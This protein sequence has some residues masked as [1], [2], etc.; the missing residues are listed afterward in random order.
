MF[1]VLIDI[2]SGMRLLYEMSSV[3]CEK[4][5]YFKN[6]CFDFVSLWLKIEEKYILLK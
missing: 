6:Y 5:R 4:R 3:Y 1:K 2:K